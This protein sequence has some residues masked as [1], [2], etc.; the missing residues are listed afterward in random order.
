MT[1]TYPNMNFFIEF[2][3]VFILRIGNHRIKLGGHLEVCPSPTEEPKDHSRLTN[4]LP[5]IQ[6]VFLGAQCSLNLSQSRHLRA[7]Q[8]NL[9]QHHRFLLP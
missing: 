7:C 4:V 3:Y 6:E 8:R 5:V 2:L 9:A 1:D